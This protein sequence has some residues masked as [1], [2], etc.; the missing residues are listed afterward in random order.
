MVKF[1]VYSDYGS[2]MT[3]ATTPARTY[4]V[5]DYATIRPMV[6]HHITRPSVP[7]SLVPLQIPSR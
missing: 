5:G 2:R 1:S 4:G 3:I 6:A 7:G